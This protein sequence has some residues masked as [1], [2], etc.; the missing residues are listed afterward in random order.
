MF[1]NIN[2]P[3]SY[4]ALFNFIIGNR[5]SGKSYGCKKWVISDFIKNKSQFAWVRRF[6]SELDDFKDN[7]FIDIKHE[8]PDVE[9]EYKSYKFYINKE[10]AGFSFPLSI[11]MKKKS[12]SYP[13]IDKLIFDEFI[14]DKGTS[15][16][17]N[18]EV[19][20]FLN[21]CETIFRMRDNWRAF[22]VANA[23]TFVNPYSL[24]FN[25]QKPIN[26]KQIW[27]KGE[28]LV[29]F[30]QSEEFIQAKK[31]SRFGKV[32]EGTDFGQFNIE[33]TFLRD[34][35]DFIIESPKKICYFFTL[36]ASNEMYG[37]WFA[38]DDGL[39]YV[40]RKYDPSYKLVYTTILENHKPNTL[41]LKGNKS[42]IFN[43]FVKAFK[44]GNVYFDSIKT[45]NVVLESIKNTL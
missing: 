22:F 2:D 40:S 10:L 21:L 44:Q 45:K 13:L 23:I 9:F 33:N 19:Q 7:F 36:K 15:H 25:L 12:Q 11:S 3:L 5:G 42:E 14:I 4:N 30:V 38:L 17:L 34:N 29:Q 37:V 6:D 39:I 35:D 43:T 8:F 18:N 24:Y 41:L 32:I 16:Y 20:I 28:F 26:K 27:R 1:W 31:N